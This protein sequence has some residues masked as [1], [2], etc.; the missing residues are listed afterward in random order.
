MPVTRDPT[1]FLQL[2]DQR[3]EHHPEAIHVR[4]YPAWP[5]HHRDP[6]ERAVGLARHSGDLEDRLLNGA[7]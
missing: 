2:L 6:A 4:P 5:V 1:A 7:G 3:L